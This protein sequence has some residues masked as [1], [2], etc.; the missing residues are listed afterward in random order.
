MA[1]EGEE[2]DSRAILYLHVLILI[3]VSGRE[4]VY[5]GWCGSNMWASLKET[6]KRKGGKGGGDERTV[7]QP[8]R[9]RRGVLEREAPPMGGTHG[10]IR[11][12]NWKTLTL[13]ITARL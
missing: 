13:P 8:V 5:P 1:F 9:E 11:S 3:G 7:Q 12:D 4:C 6:W 2:R 10:K